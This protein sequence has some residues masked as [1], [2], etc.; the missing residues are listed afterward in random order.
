[1]ERSICTD[2]ISDYPGRPT[3]CTGRLQSQHCLKE[4]IIA[5]ISQSALPQR[6]NY[7][8]YITDY[9]NKIF[10]VFKK[11]RFKLF[12]HVKLCRH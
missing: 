2:F 1:M 12:S 9:I 8:C 3:S 4:L 6:V 7:S 5:A 10:Q 11:F